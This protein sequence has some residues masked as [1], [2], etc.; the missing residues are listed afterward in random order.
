MDYQQVTTNS[1][2]AP[3]IVV[4]FPRS[5]TTLLLHILQSSGEF[6]TYDF[7]ETHFFS[8]YYRRYGAL[9]SEKNR[10][11]FLSEVSQSEWFK[12]SPITIEELIQH[13]KPDDDLYESYFTS[14]MA[15][16]ADKKNKKRWVEKT[17]YHIKYIPEIY[18]ALPD[19]KFILM[20]RDPRDSVSSLLAYGWKGGLFGSHI[21]VASAWNWHMQH[22]RKVF[23][24]FDI[25]FLTVKYE[26]LTTQTDKVLTDLNNFLDLKLD[27]DKLEKDGVGVLQK[28]NSSYTQKNTDDA[29]HSSSK[30]SITASGGRWRETMTGETLSAVE[31]ITH[32][33]MVRYGYKPESTNR[34]SELEKLKANWINSLYALQKHIRFLLFPF[35]RR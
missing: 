17:P 16:T 26:D 14:F 28:S 5:G 4:G 19:A 30:K 35:V 24:K 6:P 29:K 34:I 25:P 11:R 20:V 1:S 13:T 23:E 7:S 12:N 27:I 15:I 3:V 10:S 9:K 32:E 22:S 33:N 31:Y 8:H 18:K 21:K 2:N